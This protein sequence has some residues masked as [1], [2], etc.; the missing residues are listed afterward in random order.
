MPIK[1]QMVVVQLPNHIQLFVTPWTTACQASL[2][3]SVSWSLLKFTSI[4]SEMLSNHLI[5]CC[6]LLLLPSIFL[7][8]RVFFNKSSLRIRWPKYWSFSISP[9][10]EYSG[11]IS[12]RTDWFILLAVQWTLKRL[13]DNHKLLNEWVNEWMK[14]SWIQ[15]QWELEDLEEVSFYFYPCKE[16]FPKAWMGVTVE[17]DWESMDPRSCQTVWQ[18]E[19]MG[20]SFL[21][22]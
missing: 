11:F 4:E 7:T 12:F 20:F 16:I 10:N 3:F 15:E 18:W 8:I 13:V 17:V 21:I 19:T 6:P 1:Q 2:S 9:S 14:F 22:Y 5:L